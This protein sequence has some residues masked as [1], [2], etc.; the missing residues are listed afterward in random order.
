MVKQYDQIILSDLLF[1]T[2]SLV[3]YHLLLV[4]STTFDVIVIT[5]ILQLLKL[6]ITIQLIDKE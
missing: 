2:L 5:V 1:V 6:L 3:D 4:D